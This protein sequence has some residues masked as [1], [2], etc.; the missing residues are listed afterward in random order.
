MVA[1]DED[2]QVR[3]EPVPAALKSAATSELNQTGVD[4]PITGRAGGGGYFQ[5]DYNNPFN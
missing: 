4:A 3:P 2:Q 1:A 5:S